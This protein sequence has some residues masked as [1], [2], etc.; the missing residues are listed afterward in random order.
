[1]KLDARL[2]IIGILL[3]VL[4]M[5]V[6]TQFA[7]SGIDQEYLIIPSLDYGIRYIGS[8]NSSD[9]IKVIRAD[10]NKTNG[11][12]KLVLGNVT[13][14]SEFVYSAAFGIVNEENHSINITHMEV[15]SSNSTYLKIWL[16]GDRGA[17]A[18][19][20]SNDP[21]GVLMYNNGTI[22]NESDTI[23]W[24]LASGDNNANTICSN[25][26]DGDKYT[27]ITNWDEVADV[28]YSLND[29]NAN[30][31]ISDFVWVQIELNIPR[32]VDYAGEHAGIIY[33]HYE[34][35]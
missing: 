10:Q 20:L 23:A 21:T 28:S 25:V 18:N 26:T 17:N 27:I 29:T 6:G 35:G 11:T 16:H 13:T 8:D 14:D 33:I 32:S 3:V 19:N 4:T 34:T 30:S 7:V 22:V 12:F 15:F 2:F 24:T 9:G 5:A 1:M 31:G